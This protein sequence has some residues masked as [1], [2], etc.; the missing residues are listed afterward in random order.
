M[1]RGM[2]SSRG[3]WNALQYHHG[4]IISCKT[5]F[6]G[7]GGGERSVVET[8]SISARPSITNERRN[9]FARK[10]RAESR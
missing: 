6:N 3:A 9:A 7:G 8:L 4:D 10:E 1:N 5:S 2:L